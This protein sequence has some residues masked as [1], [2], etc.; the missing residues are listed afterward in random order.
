MAFDKRA[1]GLG[2]EKDGLPSS[3]RGLPHP[4]SCGDKWPGYCATFFRKNHHAVG[5]KEDP[6]DWMK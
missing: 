3:T 4:E 5:D 6:P 1:G 2:G